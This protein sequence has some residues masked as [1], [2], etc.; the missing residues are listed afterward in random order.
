MASKSHMT[1]GD[2]EFSLLGGLLPSIFPRQV[3]SPFVEARAAAALLA[4]GRQAAFATQAGHFHSLAAAAAAAPGQ[5]REEGGGGE[6][7]EPTKTREHQAV[8]KEPRPG[9]LLQPSM[10]IEDGRG[11]PRSSP[12]PDSLS[13]GYFSATTIATVAGGGGGLTSSRVKFY[14]A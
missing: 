10:T 4:G 7:G 3:H 6:V 12:D 1:R 14:G 5:E 9:T 2:F 13:S 8:S 11:P